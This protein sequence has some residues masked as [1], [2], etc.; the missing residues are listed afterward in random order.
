[1]DDDERMTKWEALRLVTGLTQAE[2]ER[3]LGW[4]KGY[5]SWIERG[6]RPKPDQAVQLREFYATMILVPPEVPNA[7]P[8]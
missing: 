2:V 5:L 6:A 7:A 8:E 4:K 1:M 3:R